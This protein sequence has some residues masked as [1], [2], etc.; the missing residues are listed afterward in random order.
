[1]CDYCYFVT[2][3]DPTFRMFLSPR[4]EEVLSLLLREGLR[5]VD[6]KSMG[7]VGVRLVRLLT[8][9]PLLALLLPHA[10]RSSED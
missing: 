6:R 8:V 9:A 2:N 10:T 1:M 4:G 3:R 5:Q 7:D